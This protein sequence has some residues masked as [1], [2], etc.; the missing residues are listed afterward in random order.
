[1]LQLPVVL[2]LIV[3]AERFLDQAVRVERPL[4]VAVNAN[5][6]ASAIRTGVRSRQRPMVDCAFARY[7]QTVHRHDH[8]GKSRHESLCRC[9][10]RRTSDGWSA[11]ID[12]Q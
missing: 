3:M 11:I 10:D 2:G 12:L 8:V 4:L 6:G 5:G 9:S 7:D 1:M